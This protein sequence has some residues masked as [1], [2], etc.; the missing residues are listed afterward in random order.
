MAV[1]GIAQMRPG[2][3]RASFELGIQTIICK[4]LVVTDSVE[5]GPITVVLAPGLPILFQ[6]YQFGSEYHPYCRCRSVVPE[7]V[8]DGSP[9]WDVT[10]TFTTPQIKGGA[11]GDGGNS[12]SGSDGGADKGSD[13]GGT[14]EE[15]DGQFENPLLEIPEVETHFETSQI[16][17]M[18]VYDTSQN[19]AVFKPAQ[20]ST[21]EIFVPPPHMEN[22]SLIL[23]ITRN[24]ALSAAHPQLAATYMNTCNSDT[25]WGCSAGQVKCQNITVQRQV[26]QLPGGTIFPYLRV[27]YIF[28][29]KDTWD[30]KILDSGSWYWFQKSQSEP[31]VKQRFLSEDKQPIQGLLDGNGNKLAD[32]GT[33][34]WLTIR[35]YNRLAFGALGLPQ[36]FAQVQ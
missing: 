28:K 16:P 9:A 5:D 6:P 27:T 25:F 3:P 23:T 32:G 12:D 22:A 13:G 29:I 17:I 21:G 15:T 26:K 1:V 31:K 19:P 24:E 20:A 35:P 10:C 14:K 11:H 8:K 34:V 30:L 36:S 7:R 4:Y 2:Y 18:G 33:P